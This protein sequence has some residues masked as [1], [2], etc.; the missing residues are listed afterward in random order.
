M[1]SEFIG[2]LPCK[3]R[4]PPSCSCS[5]S[6]SSL[7]FSSFLFFSIDKPEEM[8][9]DFEIDMYL[10]GQRPSLSPICL[11][12]CALSI[13]SQIPF[14]IWV[15]HHQGTSSGN[16]VKSFPPHPSHPSHPS[17]PAYPASSLSYSY[18]IGSPLTPEC[19]EKLNG[20][21]FSYG[22]LT[23]SIASTEVSL[24]LFLSSCLSLTPFSNS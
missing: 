4:I 23:S 21:S 11:V 16:S 3:D 22:W 18:H 20:Q 10:L 24:S 2:S 15:R 6:F 14:N 12:L 5:F 7:H 17:F 9:N 1:E 13:V 19:I 8:E